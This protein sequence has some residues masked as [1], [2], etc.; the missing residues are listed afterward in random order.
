[1][2]GSGG[3]RGGG[4]STEQTISGG[5]TRYPNYLRDREVFTRFLA[6]F[7]G[8]IA[9]SRPYHVSCAE[10]AHRRSQTFSLRLDDL[11]RYG[12]AD[13]ADRITRNILGYIEELSR[14]VDSVVADVVH[15]ESLVFADDSID[16]VAN[17]AHA[18]GHVLPA[19]LTRRYDFVVLP[20]SISAGIKA[21]GLPLS[22]RGLKAS[23]IGT[24]CIIKGVVVSATNVRPKVQIFTSVCDVC[25][26]ATFQNVSGDRVLPQLVC[27]S[28]RCRMTNAVGRLTAQYRACKFVKYQELRIQELPGDVPK[29]AIPRSVRVVCE[30][31][32][33]RVA[34]PGQTVKITGVHV[35]DPSTGSGREALKASTMVKTMFRALHIELDKNS[36]HNAAAA[37]KDVLDDVRRLPDRDAVIDKLARSVAPEI[38]GNEDVKKVLLCLLV[39]GSANTA[40]NESPHGKVESHL[41][42]ASEPTP[43]ANPEDA[44]VDS[45]M[46]IRPDINICL[47][48]DPGVAK[49]QLLKWVS[50][51]APRSIFTTG[52]GSSGVGLTASVAK[53]P[54][55]GEAVLEGGALVLADNGVCCIDEFDK[56]DEGDRTA[57]H[58]VMEQQTVSIAKAGIITTLNARTSILAASNPK[59]GRWRR[60]C[61]PSDNVNLP[62]ALLSRFDVLW[63]L[64]DEPEREKDTALSMHVTYLHVHGVAPG[65]LNGE[66]DPRLNTAASELD[67]DFF[68]KDFLRAYVG[69]AKRLIPHIDRTA[70]QTITELFCEMRRLRQ[71]GANVVTARTL[72]SLIRLSQAIARLRWSDRVTDLDVKE[73]ARL[74]EASKASLQ[75]RSDRTMF[76]SG[77]LTNAVGIFSA[78]KEI[79]KGRGHVQIQELRSVLTLRGVGEAALRDCLATY[80]DLA[81]VFVDAAQTTV[82]FAGVG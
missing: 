8:G 73:A 67:N 53:D 36:Y 5:E 11:V 24:L 70:A 6:E 19:G 34:T 47:M 54:H 55:T 51:V 48:G 81:V 74:I 62:P 9:G 20:V 23:A 15:R 56:M 52:K 71:R 79:A 65:R 14:C 64:L 46:S 38:W 32:Q 1:M 75:E 13:V 18:A 26:E 45:G 21:I 2:R 69:E 16:V 29:G 82:S 22:L 78:I 3:S 37:M 43:T 68:S 17:E 49:S 57:L 27:S 76:R 44:S 72:L 33:T 31:E 40:S 59:Y 80:A 61:T 77:G 66:G 39:G 4:R 60:N 58:E 12:N 7:D 35:T 41:S 25:S 42:H 50:T 30:G 10:I 28:Q 63:L